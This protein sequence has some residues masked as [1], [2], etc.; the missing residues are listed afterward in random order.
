MSFAQDLKILYHL[1]LSPVRGRTHEE[2]LESFY[3]GQADHY[4]EFRKR[5]LHGRK[6]LYEPHSHSRRRRLGGNGGRHRLQP[7]NT[8]GPTLPRSRQVHVVDL[9]ED[10]FSKIARKRIDGQVWTNVSLLHGDVTTVTLPRTGRCRDLFL[11]LD[12]DSQLVSRPGERPPIAQARR[13]HRGRRFLCGSQAPRGRLQEA[14]RLHTLVLGPPGLATTT[15]FPAPTTFPIFTTTSSQSCSRKMPASWK[16][17]P[18]CR[19]PYYLF[20]GRKTV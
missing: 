13:H 9:L 5:L 15:S 8:W 17:L 6:E 19:V 12:D 11:L 7:W 18:F 3:A 10:R 14:F 1:A 20:M 16:F 2:R 4:D